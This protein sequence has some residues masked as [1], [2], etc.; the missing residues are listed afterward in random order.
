MPSIL[1]QWERFRCF[2]VRW[3]RERTKPFHRYRWWRPS[4]ETARLVQMLINK[5][6]KFRVYPSKNDIHRLGQWNSTLK[7]LWNLAN[8]QRLNG[9]GRPSGECIYPSAFDQI[10]EFTD[11]RKQTGWIRDVPRHVGDAI[12]DRLDK[13]WQRCF[14]KISCSPKWKRKSDYVC[15]TESDPKTGSYENSN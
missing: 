12:L 6:F 3:R 14:Q 8:E 4:I 15:F 10:K 2:G 1:K 9:Y 5:T 7:F 11:L 13:A